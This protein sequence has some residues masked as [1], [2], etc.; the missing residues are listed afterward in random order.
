[1]FAQHT[2]T[3]ENLE[4]FFLVF[5]IWENNNCF[6]WQNTVEWCQLLGLKHVPVFY[7]GIFDQQKIHSLFPDTYE[8]NPTEGYVIRLADSF[9]REEFQTSIAK[10]VSSRF[11]INTDK[12]W[13]QGK[14]IPNKLKT[15]I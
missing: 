9:H 1:M 5:S 2:I 15:N 12:H 7:D 11:V 3:Y 14:V 8:G 10:F 6:S 13:M 4:S